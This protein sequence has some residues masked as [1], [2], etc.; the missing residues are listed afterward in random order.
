MAKNILTNQEAFRNL[1]KNTDQMTLA[2]IRALIV[3]MAKDNLENREQI[4][5]DHANGIFTGE[6][7]IAA[8]EE[9]L[10]H[11]GFEDR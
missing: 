2:V 3:Q 6:T 1:A 9:I 10:K 8:S 4:L 5:A 7:L 11:I